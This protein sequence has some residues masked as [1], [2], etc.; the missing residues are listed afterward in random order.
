MYVRDKQSQGEGERERGGEGGFF[1]Q[2]E[3]FLLIKKEEPF[4]GLLRRAL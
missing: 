4:G 3:A 2:S 1:F